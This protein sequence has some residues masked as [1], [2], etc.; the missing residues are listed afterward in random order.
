MKVELKLSAEEGGTL[1]CADKFC[2]LG[3]MIGAGGGAQEESRTRVK[4]AWRKF[5][6]LRPLLT[7]RGASLK[8]QGK[9]YV[10]AF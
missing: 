3:D 8:L 4:F 10:K 5:S 6:E 2:Y 9:I 1:E 7:T